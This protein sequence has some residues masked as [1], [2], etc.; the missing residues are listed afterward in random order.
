[1]HRIRYCSYKDLTHNPKKEYFMI[2]AR[3]QIVTAIFLVLVSAAAH[4]DEN[5]IDGGVLEGEDALEG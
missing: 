1:M 2:R 4:A 5:F 3:K